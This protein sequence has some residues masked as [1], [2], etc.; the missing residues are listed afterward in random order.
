MGIAG[1]KPAKS[2]YIFGFREDQTLF[3]DPHNMRPS[4]NSIEDAVKRQEFSYTNFISV[5]FDNLDPSMLIGFYL[6]DTDDLIDFYQR[7]QVFQGDHPV[8]NFT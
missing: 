2:L 4:V 6:Q 5:P 8:I 3:I 7:V 1:G